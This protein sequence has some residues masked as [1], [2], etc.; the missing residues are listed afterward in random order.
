M[1]RRKYIIT[2]RFN[3]IR[4]LTNNTSIIHLLIPDNCLD[5]Q[6]KGKL[7]RGGLNQNFGLKKPENCLFVFDCASQTTYTVI[8]IKIM[9]HRKSRIEQNVRLTTP[10]FVASQ[11]ILFLYS[12]RNYFQF[13]PNIFVRCWK[14]NLSWEG[15]PKTGFFFGRLYG[16]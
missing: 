13:S 6:K 9:V 5:I 8:C 12:N 7:Q 14:A 16:G 1:L 4:E 2:Q 3:K 11:R 15:V 10:M